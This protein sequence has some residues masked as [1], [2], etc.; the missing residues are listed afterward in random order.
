MDTLILVLVRV[1]VL[2]VLMAMT[3]S[4]QCVKQSNCICVFDDGS[5]MIDLSAIGK[6]DGTP[7]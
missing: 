6:T 3:N 2:C 5:G 1:I 7:L 4:K